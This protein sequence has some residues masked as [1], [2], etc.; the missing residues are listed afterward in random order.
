[1]ADDYGMCPEVNQAISELSKKNILSKVSVMA[2]ESIRYSSDI[3]NRV[4]TG[5][6]INLVHETG[7]GGMNQSSKKASLLKLL[8][9]IYTGRM[10]S[11]SI[12]DSIDRQYNILT[13]KGFKVSHLDT[14]QHVHVVPKILKAIVTFAKKK[15]VFSIRCITMEGKYL[16]FY[17]YSLMRFG[18]FAQVPKMILLYAMGKVMKLKLDNAHINYCKNLILMP[19]AGKGNYTGLLQKILEKFYDKD[20]EIVVHPGL[21]TMTGNGDGYRG[22][23]IE[24]FSL[25]KQEGRDRYEKK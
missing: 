16:I 11:G 14:H 23:H 9:L 21:E 25:L 18:F 4:E 5:L 12:L 19:L 7:C 24:Y 6:H 20:V 1:M 3:S 10:N 2:N 17:F 8:Y 15:D 13:S 22:R